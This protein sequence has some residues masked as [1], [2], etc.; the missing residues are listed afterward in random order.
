MDRLAKIIPRVSENNASSIAN[1]IIEDVMKFV[2]NA[3]QY[4]DMTLLVLK[5]K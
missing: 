2:G 5:I 1:A 3:E 4:D